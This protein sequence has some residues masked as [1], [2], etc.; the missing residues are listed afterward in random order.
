M[1]RRSNRSAAQSVL[2]GG[3]SDAEPDPNTPLNFFVWGG[4]PGTPMYIPHNDPLVAPIILNART[5]GTK[6][7]KKKCLNSFTPWAPLDPFH[8]HRLTPGPKVSPLAISD[9]RAPPG[10]IMT[11]GADAWYLPPPPPPHISQVCGCSISCVF[12]RPRPC[13]GAL[14]VRCHVPVSDS[15]LE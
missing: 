6:I 9:P 14:A 7:V 2:H 1:R 10:G 13:H 4:V 11:L 15:P 12:V 3:Y 8:R 5:W